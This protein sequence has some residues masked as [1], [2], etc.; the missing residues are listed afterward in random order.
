[1]NAILSL[2]IRLDRGLVR[3]GRTSAASKGIISMFA[4]EGIH[5]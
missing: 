3:A 1:M 4:S 2:S 5:V